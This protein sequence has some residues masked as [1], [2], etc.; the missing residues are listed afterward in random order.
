VL[1]YQTLHFAI[2][3][4]IPFLLCIFLVGHACPRIFQLALSLT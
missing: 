2:H 1:S 4:D 3:P